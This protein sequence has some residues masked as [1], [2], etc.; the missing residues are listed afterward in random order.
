MQGSHVLIGYLLDKD[1]QVQQLCFASE[2]MRRRCME[3]MQKA[4]WRGIEMILQAANWVGCTSKSMATL[5][6]EDYCWRK[7]I[8]D[9]PLP[10]RSLNKLAKGERLA[11]QLLPSVSGQGC[12]EDSQAICWGMVITRN[13]SEQILT[14]YPV[15][16]EDFYAAGT[17]A[18]A[19]LP[20]AK[21]LITW[22]K[23]QARILYCNVPGRAIW[24]Q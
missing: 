13:P 19:V 3:E 9:A 2:H 12:I 11:I 22:S 8:S 18:P 23:S 15:Q 24:S 14:L 16:Y 21:H 20:A 10:T 7:M 6:P 4:Q 5:T 1:Y 17:K